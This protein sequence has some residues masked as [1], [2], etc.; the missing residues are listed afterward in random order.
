MQWS[1]RCIRHDV[2]LGRGLR[3]GVVVHPLLPGAKFSDGEGAMATA[4]QRFKGHRQRW[5]V[6][7]RVGSGKT[8]PLVKCLDQH[9]KD[10][11]KNVALFPR[12][13]V[14]EELLA[15]AAQVRER[16]Q[17][18]TGTSRPCARTRCG[19][20]QLERRRWLVRFAQ[21]LERRKLCS[22]RGSVS[23][24]LVGKQ[25]AAEAARRAGST[26][27]SLICATVGID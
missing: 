5:T 13:A 19:A 9:L 3:V 10:P 27:A 20:R 17:L 15:G 8:R 21:Q 1:R 14:G 26:S 22:C 12:D 7:A 2:Q 24:L 11:R 18:A 6:D 4:Q 23:T 25:G 16:A